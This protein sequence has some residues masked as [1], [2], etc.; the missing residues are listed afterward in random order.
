MYYMVYY[1]RSHG[2]SLSPDILCADFDTLDEA[3]AFV[4]TL[5]EENDRGRQDYKAQGFSRCSHNDFIKLCHVLE[6]ACC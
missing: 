5:V 1:E 4:K 3:Q 2:A 6:E